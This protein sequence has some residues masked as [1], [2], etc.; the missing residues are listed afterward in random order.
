MRR[1]R[2]G[3]AC[4]NALEHHIFLSSHLGGLELVVEAL[5]RIKLQP[6]LVRAWFGV[7]L[8][9]SLGILRP[10]GPVPRRG[11]RSPRAVLAARGPLRIRES[12]SP[13][14]PVLGRPV[15]A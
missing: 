15:L 5:W 9:P 1:R 4:L 7:S 3:R 12:V 11:D 2:R 8:E 10:K 13:G 14:R 6:F